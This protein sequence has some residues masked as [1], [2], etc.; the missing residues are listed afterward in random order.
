MIP[1]DEPTDD[2]L[3]INCRRLDFRRPALQN[4]AT[5]SRK[6]WTVNTFIATVAVD[7]FTTG[8]YHKWIL[9]TRIPARERFSR[10]PASLIYP[11]D[12]N[13][14]F[15]SLANPGTLLAV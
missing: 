6:E 7:I 8:G 2:A 5:L 1:D 15:R 9:F 4:G 10:P 11:L 13:G 14:F 3:V 12:M